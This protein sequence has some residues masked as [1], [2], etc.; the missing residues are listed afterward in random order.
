MT[1]KIVM[2]IPT[3]LG[4]LIEVH[5]CNGFYLNLT[6]GYVRAKHTRSLER[7]K[8]KQNKTQVNLMHT[9]MLA[10]SP[11]G[12]LSSL[13]EC[14]TNETEVEVVCGRKGQ[15]QEKQVCGTKDT[16]CLMLGLKMCCE[17]LCFYLEEGHFEKETDH[18]KSPKRRLRKI[19]KTSMTSLLFATQVSC[20]R[21]TNKEECRFLVRKMKPMR[22]CCK[23]SFSAPSFKQKQ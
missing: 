22:S 20:K 6:T 19:V 11:S 17:W 5:L 7:I 4:T 8:N 21:K 15:N 23:C 13:A 1:D 2:I 14:Q 10:E 9:N 16:Y 12:S 18:N 3:P